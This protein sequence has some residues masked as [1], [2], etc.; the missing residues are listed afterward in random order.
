[1]ESGGSYD[2][3]ILLLFLDRFFLR[4]YLIMSKIPNHFK[5]ESQKAPIY[6]N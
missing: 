2:P 3:L 1:M 6:Y 4:F 5:N